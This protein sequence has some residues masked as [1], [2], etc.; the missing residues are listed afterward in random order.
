M[1]EM[2][3]ASATSMPL[4]ELEPSSGNLPLNTD[5]SRWASVTP[6]DSSTWSEVMESSGNKLMEGTSAWGVVVAISASTSR[7]SSI[8]SRK[9]LT[10]MKLFESISRLVLFMLLR[11]HSRNNPVYKLNRRAFSYCE[12]CIPS[13]AP[14]HPTHNKIG[15]LLLLLYPKNPTFL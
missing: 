1:A 7:S 13:R 2:L 6:F 8:G 9:V 15:H 4:P 12:Q 11:I 14:P 10:M 5:S 3:A